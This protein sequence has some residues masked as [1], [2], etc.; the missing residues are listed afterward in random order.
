MSIV[1]FLRG[2]QCL[3]D[4][5][6]Y[7]LTICLCAALIL[8]F[9]AAF[10]APMTDA[11]YLVKLTVQDDVVVV[12]GTLGYCWKKS[13]VEACSK[14]AA[15]YQLGQWRQACL[16]TIIR[17]TDSQFCWCKRRGNLC[18]EPNCTPINTAMEYYH[19]LSTGR[20]LRSHIHCLCNHYIS[21]F[22]AYLFRAMAPGILRHCCT[23]ATDMLYL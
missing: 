21:P 15:G 23:S 4:E 11:I 5:P 16:S 2:S 17:D 12:L 7:A 1:S 3:Y 13:G 20:D 10:S 9:F 6:R 22:R 14:V 8:I 18:P 19:P